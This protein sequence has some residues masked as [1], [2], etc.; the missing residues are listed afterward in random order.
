[1]MAVASMKES[2]EVLGFE[3]YEQAIAARRRTCYFSYAI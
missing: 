2:P 3:R 1:M